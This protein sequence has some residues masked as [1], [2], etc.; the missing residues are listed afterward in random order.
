MRS[1]KPKHELLAKSN[2]IASEGFGL[3]SLSGRNGFSSTSRP[4]PA[5]NQHFI[6]IL[7]NFKI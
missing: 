2:S 7:T 1:E 3:E 5:Y 4:K 6:K